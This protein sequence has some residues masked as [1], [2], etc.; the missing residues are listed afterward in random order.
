MCAQNRNEVKKMINNDYN[1]ILEFH[2]IKER[3]KEYA[4]TEYGKKKI[5]ELKPILREVQV[6]KMQQET[7]SAKNIIDYAGNPPIPNTSQIKNLIEIAEKEGI[8]YPEQLEQMMSFVAACKRLKNYL[9]KAETT[10]EGLAFTGENLDMLKEIQEEINRCI[11]GND[12]DTHASGELCRIRRSI[13]QI[14]QEIKN[15]IEGILRTKKKYLADAFLSIKNGH[16]TLPVKKE[17]KNQIIGSV[18]T[19]SGTGST[20]FIEPKAVANLV[21]ECEELKNEEMLEKN[22]ILYSLTALIYQYYKEI[23]LNMEIIE[24]LDFIFAKGKLSIDMEAAAPEINTER[25][26][27]IEKGRHPLLNKEVCI[28]LDFEIGGDIRGIVIT[29]PNTGGK[30]V[31]LKLIG[32]FSLMAQCG[33]HLPCKSA[34][35]CLNSNILCD[36]GDGQNISENL[37]TFSSHI[38][39]II[40]ILERTNEESLVLLDE[41]GS[42]TDPAEGMSLAVAILDELRRKKCLFVTTTHYTEVKTYAEQTMYLK[43][44]RMTFDKETLKPKYQLI[45][46]EAGES[47]ALY[48]AKCLGLPEHLLALAAQQT[49][50]DFITELSYNKWKAEKEKRN[51]GN[52]E[53]SKEKRQAYLQAERIQKTPREKKQSAHA[54]SF[55]MGDSVIVYPDKAIGIVYKA[56]DEDGFVIVQIKG[57]KC[58]VNHKRLK[59]KAS[60][61]ELYPKDYDFSI[62]FDSV[63]V[64]KARHQMNR[65]Y[66]ENI[67]IRHQEE[68]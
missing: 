21:Q 58:R 28:P 62:I 17:Y 64:R 48:I 44:A 59:L 37:S 5:E 20:C 67:E 57:K 19:V 33:L 24:T 43:N 61:A 42:G 35:I 31:A 56:S 50:G 52:T 14:E 22:R 36:I 23:M 1:K 25:Y 7:Q 60:A 49:E 16:Y 68:N 2:I 40:K 55:Q 6:R 66:C 27:K 63:E 29:G 38:K 46:G 39:N 26:I 11:R 13:S 8:L 18:I 34:N 30:T 12:V 10:K 45:I 65:K 3:L 9:K 54:L 47:C 41:L 32:L 51:I 4:A 53:N 15:K